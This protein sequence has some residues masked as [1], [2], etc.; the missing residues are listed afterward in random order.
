MS[1]ADV[2]LREHAI[3]HP[4]A[5]TGADFG[6]DWVYAGLSAEQFR[7]R[8][9][10]LNSVAWL[11]WHVARVEDACVA[12]IVLGRS[13][14]LDDDW[15]ERL[16]VDERGD[17]EGMSK[18]DVARLSDAIDLRAL[19]DYRAEVCRRSRELVAEVPPSLWH[20]PLTDDEIDARVE[21]GV[22]SADEAPRLRGRARDGMLFWW[23]VEHTHYHLGQIAMLRGLLSD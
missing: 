15:T 13:Q 19:L 10:G 1:P 2:F 21:S 11:L 4:P 5:V 12:G 6:M 7:A 23:G 9:H 20:A 18:Q 14:V 22:L 17:G 8:P 3:V 16:G